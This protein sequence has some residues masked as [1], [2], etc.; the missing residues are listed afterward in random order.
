MSRIFFLQ[1]FEICEVLGEI[2]D[3]D[4]MKEVRIYR[5]KFTSV[6]LRVMQG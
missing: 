1:F 2:V 3:R 5:R 6:L 4:M